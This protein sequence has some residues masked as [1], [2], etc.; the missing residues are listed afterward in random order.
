MN[1]VIA[2]DSLKGSLSSL[3]A[4]TATAEGIRRVFPDAKI[5]IFPIADG[6]EGTVDALVTAKSSRLLL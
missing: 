2:I 1:A 6:G 4:G 5:E 3:Q